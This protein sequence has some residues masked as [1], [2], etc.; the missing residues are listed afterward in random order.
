MGKSTCD[1]AAPCGMERI[2]MPGFTYLA[3]MLG[4]IAVIAV[5]VIPSLLRK[6]CPSCGTRNSLD[7]RVCSSCGGPFPGEG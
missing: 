5:V 3:V 1:R 4:V 2:G 7:A 6:K